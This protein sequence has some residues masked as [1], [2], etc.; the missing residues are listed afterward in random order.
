MIA[1]SDATEA[2]DLAHDVRVDDE[3]LAECASR[4]QPVGLEE[5]GNVATRVGHQVIFTGI[6]A[7]IRSASLTNTLWCNT[8]PI[9][10]GTRVE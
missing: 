4:G 1:R 5:R 3:V 8:M 2:R 10:G 9:P 6:G 7:S